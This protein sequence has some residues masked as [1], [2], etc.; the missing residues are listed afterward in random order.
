MEE[1]KILSAQQ[2][3]KLFGAVI[4]FMY[5]CRIS[6]STIRESFEEALVDIKR[7]QA[8]A[9]VKRRSGLY[10]QAQ[11]LPAQLL[12]V[13]HRDSR[14]LDNEAKPLPLAITRGRASL[15]SIVRQIDASANASAL[16][17]NMKA[18][19]LIRRTSAGKYIPT[20]ESAIVDRLHP[21]AVEHVTK[22]VTRLMSTVSRNTNPQSGSLSLVDRHAYTSDL[23]PT[24]RV[25][26]AE[27]TRSQGMAYLESI[28]D[29]LEHRRVRNRLSSKRVKREGLAAGVYLFAYLSDANVASSSE[30]LIP[31]AERQLRAVRTK[32]S[33]LRSKRPRPSREALA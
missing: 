1:G 13:W 15:H 33:T 24:D 29:W 4:E 9:R 10:M 11:N 19:G 12:R 27:F 30:E 5:H 17:Q 16:I 2:R 31:L 20:S 8:N 32:P 14:Y 25:A 21:L 23:S 28:D 6:E 3:L 7:G 26:F 18:V 22:L